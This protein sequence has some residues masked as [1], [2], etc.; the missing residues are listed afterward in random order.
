MNVCIKLCVMC[1]RLKYMMS[2]EMVCL[3]VSV[4][5]CVILYTLF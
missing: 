2:V 3:G 5:V 4:C 1:I